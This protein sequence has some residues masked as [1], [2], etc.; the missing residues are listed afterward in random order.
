MA[1]FNQGGGSLHAICI[2]PI[3]ISRMLKRNRTRWSLATHAGAAGKRSKKRVLSS[4]R[5]APLLSQLKTMRNNAF[6]HTLAYNQEKALP[7]D[8]S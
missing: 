5:V 1:R 7:E 3:A 4:G 6:S 8:F 2:S